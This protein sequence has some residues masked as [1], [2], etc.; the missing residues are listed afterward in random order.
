MAGGSKAFPV[1]DCQKIILRKEPGSSLKISTVG[2]G[3]F[4][5]WT[6]VNNML[7]IE[8][9]TRYPYVGNMNFEENMFQISK[10]RELFSVLLEAIG[11]N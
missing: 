7:C 8:P 9:I 5:L 4:M 6:E 2:F 11:P 1:L 10:G 3:H